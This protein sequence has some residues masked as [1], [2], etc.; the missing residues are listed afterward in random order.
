MKGLQLFNLLPMK[1]MKEQEK[2][3]FKIIPAM[4]VIV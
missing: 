3:Q 2:V 1:E 4:I